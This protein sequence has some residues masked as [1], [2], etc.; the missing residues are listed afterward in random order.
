MPTA[1]APAFPGCFPDNFEADILPKNLPPLTLRVYRVCVRGILSREAFLSSF[2]EVLRG[3]KPKPRGWDKKLKDP[4]AYSTS[5]D[6]DEDSARGTLDCL[7]R[8]NPPA[9]LACGEASSDY[10]PVQKTRERTGTDTSHVDW[11]LYAGADPSGRFQVV[12]EDEAE[13]DAD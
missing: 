10:G 4:I 5:C 6:Y 13:E 12:S 7:R 11:W 8:Y 1:L 3:D 2:E 9:V